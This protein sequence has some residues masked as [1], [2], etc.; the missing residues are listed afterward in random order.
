MHFGIGALRA[1]FF[2]SSVYRFAFLPSGIDTAFL[3]WEHVDTP[4]GS[5]NLGV[6][7]STTG[8]ESELVDVDKASFARLVSL[9]SPKELT[10]ELDIGRLRAC[11]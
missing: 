7:P 2:S 9:D 8:R 5:G 4:L 1:L 6:L 10:L 3:V 11:L